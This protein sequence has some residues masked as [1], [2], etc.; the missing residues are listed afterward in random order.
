MSQ[1]TQSRPP[2][3]LQPGNRCENIELHEKPQSKAPKCRTQTHQR[4]TLR[5]RSSGDGVTGAGQSGYSKEIKPIQK[6]PG[7]E[8]ARLER[9]THADQSNLDDAVKHKIKPEQWQWKRRSHQ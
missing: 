9:D 4:T 3:Q 2:L 5:I 8:I 1:Q 7:Q 6:R